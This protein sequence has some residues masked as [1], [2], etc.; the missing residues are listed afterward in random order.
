MGPGPNLQKRL[1]D[2][3]MDE[4]RRVEPHPTQGTAAVVAAFFD[5]SFFWRVSLAIAAV[6]FCFQFDWYMLRFLTSEATLRITAVLGLPIQ[7][8]AFDKL[9]YR[10]CLINFTVTCTWINGLFGIVP[11]LRVY[12]SWRENLR[13]MAIFVPGFFLANLVRI[14]IIIL[15]YRPRISWNLEHGWITGL[16]E[17]L[18]YLWVLSL[19]DHPLARFLRFGELPHSRALAAKTGVAGDVPADVEF[20]IKRRLHTITDDGSAE[21][22]G[23][24]DEKQSEICRRG[25]Y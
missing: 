14:E 19:I 5:P 20:G 22:G 13:R 12:G 2:G 23:G 17:F 6:L 16:S 4:T 25:P 7:R 24:A 10:D 18:V 3:S 11:L 15:I 9:K 21:L 1:V 8:V